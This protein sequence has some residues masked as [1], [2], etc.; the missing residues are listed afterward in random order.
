MK[1][2][3]LMTTWKL[4]KS[5]GK[6]CRLEPME[7]KTNIQ[8]NTPLSQTPKTTHTKYLFQNEQVMTIM[9]PLPQLSLTNLL[10]GKASHKIQDFYSIYLDSWGTLFQPYSITYNH[11]NS[12]FLTQ[13][14]STKLFNSTLQPIG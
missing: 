7:E 10:Q 4:C 2:I 5:Y 6:A 9:Q 13:P 14:N 1:A 11:Y 12:N 3:E 8:Q